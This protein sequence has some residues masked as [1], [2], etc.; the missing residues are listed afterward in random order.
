[1]KTYIFADKNKFDKMYQ[2]FFAMRVFHRIDEQ[3]Q[4]LIKFATK[5]LEK[6]LMEIPDIKNEL[7]ELKENEK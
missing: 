1:M 4:L 6:E 2:H 3:G 7:T 5:N